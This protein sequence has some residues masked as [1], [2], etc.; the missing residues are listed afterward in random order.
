MNNGIIEQYGTPEEIYQ[1]PTTEFV[2]RFIG[3]ENFIKGTVQDS[4]TVQLSNGL[5]LETLEH[6]KEGE[7]DGNDSS[8]PYR[9]LERGDVFFQ[10]KF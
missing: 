6:A 8:R 4:H 2:A 5:V 9:T 3:F 1:H 7:C 10:A